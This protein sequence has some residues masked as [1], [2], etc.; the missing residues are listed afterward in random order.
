MGDRAALDGR[1][2]STGS[3]Y[4]RGDSLFSHHFYGEIHSF[5]LKRLRKRLNPAQFRSRSRWLLSLETTTTMG[6]CWP[7]SAKRTAAA[8]AARWFIHPAPAISTTRFAARV[9]VAEFHF[10]LAGPFYTAAHDILHVIYQS[11]AHCRR[12]LWVGRRRSPKLGSP[13]I[14]VRVKG[15]FVARR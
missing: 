2:F 6:V 11:D 9:E 14:P 5:S 12:L 8:G 10:V 13:A 7:L 1:Q 4:T 15:R 3:L